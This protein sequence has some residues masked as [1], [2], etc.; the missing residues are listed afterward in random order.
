MTSV[1]SYATTKPYD[2]NYYAFVA[3]DESKTDLPLPYSWVV[4]A[5]STGEKSY[6]TDEY[7]E[8]HNPWTEFPGWLVPIKLP[9]NCTKIKFTQL[10][11][12]YGVYPLFYQYNV[13]SEAELTVKKI[14]STLPIN[15]Y[16]MAYEAETVIDVP[17][18]YDSFVCTWKWKPNSASDKFD[19]MSDADLAKFTVE[20][21]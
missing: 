16:D 4:N 13:P 7:I 14:A 10:N 8:S 18:G 5:T 2:K 15:S 21:M 19:V 1:E 20:F 12:D 11:A 17:N 6:Q 3:I 9:H